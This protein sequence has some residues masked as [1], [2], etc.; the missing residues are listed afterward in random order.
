MTEE[1]SDWT[2]RYGDKHNE[3]RKLRRQTDPEYAEKHRER[4]R[5]YAKRKR[6]ELLGRIY[7]TY[8]NEEL[9]VF[10]VSELLTKAN[11]TYRKYR[12]WLDKGLIPPSIFDGTHAVYTEHQIKLLCKVFKNGVDFEKHKKYLLKRWE[13]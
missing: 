1:K 10:R 13:P 3:K 6:K 12:W 7:K 4:S 9:E 11:I 2:K 5:I 8:N